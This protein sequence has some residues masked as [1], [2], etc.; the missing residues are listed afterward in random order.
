[1]AIEGPMGDDCHSAARLHKDSP[2]RQLLPARD[3]ASL[4]QHRGSE[5]I[6]APIVGQPT[7]VQRDSDS[8]TAPPRCLLLPSDLP[9]ASPSRRRSYSRPRQHGGLVLQCPRCASI[10]SLFPS[11][12]SRPML[13]RVLTSRGVPSWL[14]PT[15]SRQRHPRHPAEPVVPLILSQSRYPSPRSSLRISSVS[16]TGGA[17]SRAS[18]SR[19]WRCSCSHRAISCSS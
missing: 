17:G 18:T 14:P 2:R 8:S 15:A 10:N 7:W 16:S 1:M 3:Q 5:G 19:Q 12:G 9:L 11:V 13:R 6:A 4:E